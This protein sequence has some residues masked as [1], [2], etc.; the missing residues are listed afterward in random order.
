MMNRVQLLICDVD[1]TLL[2][3]DKRL[4]QASLDAVARLRASQVRFAITSGRPP[5]GMAMLI[6]PLRLAT[7]IAA[8]NGGMLM[9][10][11][12]K[13]VLDQK[14]LPVGVG[15]QVLDFLLQ[16]GLEAWVYRGQDWFVRSVDTPRV[17]HERRTVGFE[18]SR[19]AE[20][21]EVL[22]GA[23]KIV[24]AT[25]DPRL[26]A[27]CEAEIRKRVE[28][29][30]SASRSQPYYLD[31]THPDA[32]KGE[33]V[34]LVSRI[35]GIPLEEI[36]VMGDMPNDVLMFSVAGASIAMG[37][38]SPEVRRAARSVTLSNQ[39]EGFAYAVDHFILDAGRDGRKPVPE[40]LGLPADARACLF[41]L[42]GV[43][44]RTA[45]VHARAWKEVFDGVLREW[46][47]RENKS[48][49]PFDADEDYTLHVDGKLREEGARSFLASRGI[50]LPERELAELVDRKDLIFVQILQKEPV[51]VYEGSVRYVHRA[52]DAG[53][54]VAVVSS[55]RHCQEVLASAGIS[56]L[57]E[58]RVDGNVSAERHLAGK[59]APDSY[60]AAARA[61]DV[62]PGHAAVF[63]D[64]LSGVE[65]G[66][67]GHFG[68]VVGV[69]RAGHGDAL[70]EHGATVVV[71][72]LSALLS[73]REGCR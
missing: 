61:L 27:R 60:L 66:R 37:N 70:R 16:S 72:D 20:L 12:L 59:P 54:R 6:E 11:D 67:N 56:G 4:T 39:A 36:A 5:R 65:A 42:D 17:A 64:A 1:G 10:P 29:H 44:T 38:A 3:P 7:P 21:D 62:A 73:G 51:E 30:A 48:F 2:T 9:S 22:E 57:F 18:P 31:I 24:G 71:S 34:R 47:R 40:D 8:F 68:C 32:N 45:K 41:D 53:L 23:V 52:R 19:V 26:M 69:D 46:A 35:L 33:V 55:S 13:T 25:D 28:G 49:V 15:H 58:A 43:L 14:V 50:D 63:E